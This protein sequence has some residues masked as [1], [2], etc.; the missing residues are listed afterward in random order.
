MNRFCAW[1]SDTESEHLRGLC[2][3]LGA[4]YIFLLSHNFDICLPLHL[5]FVLLAG[6]VGN[7]CLFTGPVQFGILPFIVLEGKA[8]ALGGLKV[9]FLFAVQIELVFE[10]SRAH[11]L[12]KHIWVHTHIRMLCLTVQI[13]KWLHLR[14]RVF[15]EPLGRWFRRLAFLRREEDSSHAQR[16]ASPGVHFPDRFAFPC[17]Y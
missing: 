2:F 15:N 14:T 16:R 6:F 12:R 7:P 17:S 13:F 3:V 4:N 9:D 8:A 1:I 10:H 5:L 11:C